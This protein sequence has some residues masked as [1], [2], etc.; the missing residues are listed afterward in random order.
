MDQSKCIEEINLDNAEEFIEYLTLT[1]SRWKPEKPLWNEEFNSPWIFRGHRDATWVLQPRVW[2]A[3]GQKIIAPILERLRNKIQR[4]EI[5]SIELLLPHDLYPGKDIKVTNFIHVAAEYDVVN[6]FVEMADKLGYPI[7]DSQN[8]VNGVQFLNCPTKFQWPSFRPNSIMG[9]AQHHGIPTRLLDWT[10]NPLV[11]AF[12]ASESDEIEAE[13]IAVWA[14]NLNLLNIHKGA[15]KHL[16]LRILTCPR[17]QHGFLHAQ[18]AL[19]LWD[20]GANQHF[21]EYGTWP[22]FENIIEGPLTTFDE[23]RPKP[24]RKITLPSQEANRVLQLL[25]RARISRAHLMPT[26]DNI[27]AALRL[28]WGW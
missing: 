7:P 20:A 19:F 11:A 8:L 10:Y 4:R 1:N 17:Y 12:F 28:K 21:L 15:W 6:Q 13:R 24:L 5:R 23:G 22:V 14:L 25:W 27:T 18:D 16:R 26:Y 3:D 9:L 2:R